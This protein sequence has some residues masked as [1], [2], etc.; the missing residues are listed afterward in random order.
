VMM[1]KVS[2]LSKALTLSCLTGK[3]RLASQRNMLRKYGR[4]LDL[5]APY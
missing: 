2:L 4:I 3:L 1:T 5:K